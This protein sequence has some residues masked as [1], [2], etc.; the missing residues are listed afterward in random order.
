MAL[1]RLILC[2]IV[3]PLMDI[4]L[5]GKNT[6]EVMQKTGFRFLLRSLFFVSIFILISGISESAPLLILL[7]AAGV[8]G[9]LVWKF[10]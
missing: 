7:G 3:T 4:F 9:V 5:L 10:R 8:I 6:D 2:Y 1:I